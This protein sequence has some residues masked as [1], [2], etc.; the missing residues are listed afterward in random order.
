[1]ET[2]SEIL[3]TVLSTN[4]LAESL[5]DLA[6]KLGY[7]GRSTLYRLIN[8]NASERA[9]SG[10]CKKLE[11]TLLIDEESLNSMRI[12]II[13]TGTFHRLL[14]PYIK[15]IGSHTVYDFVDAFISMNFEK[16][17]EDFRRQNLEELLDLERSDHDAFYNMLA[18]FY[19]KYSNVDYYIKGASHRERSAKVLKSLCEKFI[20]QYPEN[21]LAANSVF[22]YSKSEILNGEVPILWSLIRTLASVL[23]MYARPVE[24]LERDIKTLRLSN[25]R[26]YWESNDDKSVILTYAIH[27]LSPRGYNY[28]TYK[29][30]RESGDID[31]LGC[32]SFLS[33]DILSF[34]SASQK[35]SKLGVFEFDGRELSMEWEKAND[36]P[37]TAGNK[38]TLVDKKN[39]QSLRNLDRSIDEESLFIEKLKSQG[40]RDMEEYHVVDV[41]ISRETLVLKLR[42]RRSLS[43]SINE[44][45]FLQKLKPEYLVLICERE[46]DNIPF[47]CW[48]QILHS[49][50]MCYFEKY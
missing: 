5:G 37:T 44:V 47:V 41:I 13:N 23:Q 30:S 26:E 11:E 2:I 10:F 34:F 1:M 42:N 15:P 32:L 35:T 16:L 27:N 21:D 48:P 14:K 25:E 39:S 50:P 19:Y 18:Y 36:D 4:L 17:P 9:I 8:G 46:S 20:R 12:T 28:D 31:Y 6:N 38:W 45:P 3:K 33:D 24:I 40:W 29:I 49:L 22:L 43:I 7:R